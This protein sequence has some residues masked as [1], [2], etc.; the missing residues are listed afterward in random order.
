MGANRESRILSQAGQPSLGLDTLFSGYGP[1]SKKG[2]QQRWEERDQGPPAEAR[3]RVPTSPRGLIPM[4]TGS[5]CQPAGV[6][7][8]V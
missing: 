3:I 8:V 1:A 7:A 4:S 2:S 6:R 5:Q